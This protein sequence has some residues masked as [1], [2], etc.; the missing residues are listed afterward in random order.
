MDE[1]A[2]GFLNSLINEEI[3]SFVLTGLRKRL[4]SKTQLSRQIL[5]VLC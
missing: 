2:I 5:L 3:V 4:D 1:R